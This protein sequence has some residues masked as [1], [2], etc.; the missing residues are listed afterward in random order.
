MNLA[1]VQTI[2]ATSPVDKSKINPMWKC[3]FEGFGNNIVV[4]LWICDQ[5]LKE[6]FEDFAREEFGDAV[7]QI[8]RMGNYPKIELNKG[9]S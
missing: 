4:Q 3:V 2:L 9:L 6:S 5:D 1:W 8:V 7:Q